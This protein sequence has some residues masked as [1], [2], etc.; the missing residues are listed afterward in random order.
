M[1]AG[2][3]IRVRPIMVTETG[4]SLGI[5][6]YEDLANPTIGKSICVRSSGNIYN[7]SLIAGMLNSIQ[8]SEAE[9]WASGIVNNMARAPQGGDR[10]QIRAAAAGQCSV[11]IANTYYLANMLANQEKQNDYQAGQAMTIIWPN[12]NGRGAHVNVSGAGILKTAPNKENALKLIEYLASEKAQKMYAN[13]NFEYPAMNNIE[14]NP[15]LQQWG[16]FKADSVNLSF[17]GEKN[18]AAVKILDRAGWK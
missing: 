12:Q 4:K 7:Q 13:V 6:S 10:D 3:S 16:D 8:E 17:L 15:I 18:S 5:T 14:L 2:L 11:V 9:A 1:W